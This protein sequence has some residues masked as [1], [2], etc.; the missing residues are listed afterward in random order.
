MSSWLNFTVRASKYSFRVYRAQNAG[1]N[2]HL[3]QCQPYGDIASVDN[4]PLRLVHGARSRVKVI[5][6]GLAE[7]SSD[8]GL[9]GG[10]SL[11]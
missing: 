11:S 3:I 10:V 9:T 8:L 4:N 5:S 7:R 1:K 6:K 2:H